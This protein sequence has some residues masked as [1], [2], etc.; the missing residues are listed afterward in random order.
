[1]S[2]HYEKNDLEKFNAKIITYSQTLNSVLKL[3][4]ANFEFI[5]LNRKQLF[6]KDGKGLIDYIEP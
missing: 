6:D 1:M 2:D 4:K 5:N 3:R